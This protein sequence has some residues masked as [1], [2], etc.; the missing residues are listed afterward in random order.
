MTY[1][2]NDETWQVWSLTDMPMSV[3]LV[4]EGQFRWKNVNNLQ[5]RTEETRTL[6]LHRSRLT[7]QTRTERTTMTEPNH[8]P[9]PHDVTT[10]QIEA[11]IECQNVT[12]GQLAGVTEY[13][14][15]IAREVAFFKT[16]TIIWLVFV[17]IYLVFTYIGSLT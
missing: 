11:V 17:I 7:N 13:L 3:W 12:S 16:I 1:L 4:R 2:D 6:R 9:T 14:R 15:R 10:A 5:V 8:E